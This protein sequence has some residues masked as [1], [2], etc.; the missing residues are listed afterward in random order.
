MHMRG[1]R[2]ARKVLASHERGDARAHDA[3][4]YRHVRAANPAGIFPSRIREPRSLRWTLHGEVGRAGDKPV[5]MILPR[6]ARP[7]TRQRA[8]YQ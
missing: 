8:R 6:L 1:V 7:L 2:G 5:H 4:D 3:R